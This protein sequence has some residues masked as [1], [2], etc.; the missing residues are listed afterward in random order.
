[1]VYH[2]C[3]VRK[4]AYHAGSDVRILAL[5]HA[6][7]SAS[8]FGRQKQTIFVSSLSLFSPTRKVGDLFGKP[9]AI[10]DSLHRTPTCE[11]GAF[12]STLERTFCCFVSIFPS[13]ASRVVA[14][15][16]SSLGFL[17]VQ[18]SHDEKE[19]A[20][21]PLPSTSQLS[22]SFIWIGVQFRLKSVYK[23]QFFRCLIS[24]LAIT[25]C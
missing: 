6:T 20:E 23:T 25:V 16:Q 22:F 17:T 2:L 1:M 14:E 3:T 19:E 24:L 15:I 21:F 8:A 11:L 9:S 4:I 13:P 12:C 10:T 18:T 5:D 7:L